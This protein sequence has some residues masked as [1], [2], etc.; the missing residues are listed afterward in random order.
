VL[1]GRNAAGKWGFELAGDVHEG[2][3][4]RVAKL[5]DER[6]LAYS[7]PLAEVGLDIDALDD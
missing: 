7:V 4:P 1:L 2:M 3:L 6:Q 5:T